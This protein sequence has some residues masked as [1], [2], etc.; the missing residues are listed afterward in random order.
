MFFGGL[1]VLAFIYVMNL[2]LE[3]NYTFG[4]WFSQ[5]SRK[6]AMLIVD[7]YIAL[8]YKY[9]EMECTNNRHLTNYGQK[10]VQKSS[11]TIRSQ[12]L[13]GRQPIS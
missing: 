6:N 10:K 12:L 1:K 11:T 2:V 8:F 4:P 3:Q 5:D 7:L 9:F 13:M